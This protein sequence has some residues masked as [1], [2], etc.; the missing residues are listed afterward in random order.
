MDHQKIN[1]F[2]LFVGLLRFRSH[3]DLLRRA[4]TATQ[5]DASTKRQRITTPRIRRIR[6]H[7]P[8]SR[9]DQIERHE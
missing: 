4:G 1:H 5:R 2:C 3:F 7:D 8:T 9:A 6:G